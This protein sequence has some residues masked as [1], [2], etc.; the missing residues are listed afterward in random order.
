VLDGLEF[1]SG[2]TTLGSGTFEVLGTLAGFLTDN[3]GLN[4]ALVGHTDTVGGLEGNIRISKERAEAVRARLIERYGI[5]AARMEAEGMGYLAPLSSN[6]TEAGRESN[7]RVE[8]ILLS[9]R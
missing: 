6:L 8:V 7:R 1:D 9:T 5:S 3:P 4:V 2:A